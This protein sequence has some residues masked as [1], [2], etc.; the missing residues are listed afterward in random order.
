MY[1]N[2]NNHKFK[3]QVGKRHMQNIYIYSVFLVSSVHISMYTCKMS[4][5]IYVDI[6]EP[7]TIKIIT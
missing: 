1:Q 4:M 5:L 2:N 7:I 3:A 6:L